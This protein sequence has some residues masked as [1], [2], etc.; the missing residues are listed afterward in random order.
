MSHSPL[1]TFPSK[2][3]T[4]LSCLRPSRLDMFHRTLYLHDP[5]SAHASAYYPGRTLEGWLRW[6]HKQNTMPLST[7]ERLLSGSLEYSAVD[8]VA[9]GGLL[10]H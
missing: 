6:H 10:R 3:D 1:S 2:P 5:K 8:F 7:A 9:A 4:D